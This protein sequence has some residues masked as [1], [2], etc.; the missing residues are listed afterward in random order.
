MSANSIIPVPGRR[1]GHLSKWEAFSVYWVI[2][3]LAGS[4][5]LLAIRLSNLYSIL[6][7][8]LWCLLAWFVAFVAVAVIK[9]LNGTRAFSSKRNFVVQLLMIPIRALV[10]ASGMLLA[11][12]SMVTGGT[13]ILHV[14]VLAALEYLVVDLLIFYALAY[15]AS[16]LI[17][18]LVTKN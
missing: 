1:Q 12:Q 5:V 13:V 8:F 2:I 14:T 4:G 11:A 18:W 15:G 6:Q 17:V 7:Y 10:Y 3:P 16:Y 9:K